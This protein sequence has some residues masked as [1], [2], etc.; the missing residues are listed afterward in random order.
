MSSE[1][2]FKLEHADRL[3]AGRQH[4]IAEAPNARQQ[5]TI[6]AASVMLISLSPDARCACN[7]ASTCCS[8]MARVLSN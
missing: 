7:A 6:F 8:D 5:P 4:L 3:G 1:F 2:W